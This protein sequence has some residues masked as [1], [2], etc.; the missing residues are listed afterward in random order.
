MGNL[1]AQGLFNKH[2]AAL[3]QARSACRTREYFSLFPETPDRHIGGQ[4][5]ADASIES[6]KAQLG[7]A[8]SLHQP[9]EIGRIT[10]E[11]SPY[12]QEVLAIDYPQ[13]NPDVLFSA[14]R[15]AMPVW[16]AASVQERVGVCMEIIDRLYRNIFQS[17]HAVMHTSGQSFLMS[18][19]GSGTNALDRGVEAVAYAYAAMSDIPTEAIW[20]RRFGTTNIKLRKKYLLVPR[21]VAVCFTCATFATWNAYPAILANLAT[22]NPV[23]VKPHPSAI[24]P[25]ALAVRE[26]RQ[27][28]IEAGFAADLITLC[29]DTIDHPLGKTLVRHQHTAIVDFTGS[30]RFGAW[31]ESNA[32]PALCYSETSG[33]NTVVIESVESLEPVIKSLATSLSLFSAQM[34][35]SPQNIYIPASGVRCGSGNVSV[36]EFSEALA[37]AISGISADP[38][39]AGNIL[40]AIQS[41]VTLSLI[42]QMTDQAQRY[43]R[44]ILASTPYIHREFPNARTSSPL[45]IATNIGG[46][47][48]YAEERFGPI[49]FV[50]QVADRASA[51]SAA[52]EDARLGGA[53]TA[54]LYSTDEQY[55]SAAEQGFSACGAQL[56]CNLT[57]P[58]PINFAAAYSDYHVSGLNPAGN[59]TL[60]DLSFVASR[61]RVT[62]SRSPV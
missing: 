18:Y 22:G 40:A 28:L 43:G 6:F 5:A 37:S 16:A 54:F 23:I 38:I 42:E 10:G 30:A 57:G 44:V 29:L 52:V 39:R 9:G 51:L 32:S 12:M 3:E 13:S 34:C 62:Q 60:T 15:A 50:I 49:G 53:I 46:R 8:F 24:L 36:E 11:V 41:P 21:G 61:F 58:M 27:V 20:E 17:A 7:C 14:A 35:T 56:T 59:A 31:V 19:T 47:E 55:I 2:Q 26:C 1:L 48:L 45:L 33:V 4:I 25:M